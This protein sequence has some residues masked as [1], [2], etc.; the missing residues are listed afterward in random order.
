MLKTHSNCNHFA[1]DLCERLTGKPAPEW[2]NRLAWFADKAKFMLP[3][4]FDNPTAAPVTADAAEAAQ[5]EP[6]PGAEG[7]DADSW[8]G[9][10]QERDPD[11][12]D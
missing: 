3:A 11:H 10:L 12:S 5:R 1:S 7:D 8:D 6:Q 9:D 4:G 2:V